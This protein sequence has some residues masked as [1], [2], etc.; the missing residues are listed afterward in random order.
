MSNQPL[1]QSS[2]AVPSDL[3]SLR[4]LDLKLFFAGMESANTV[5]P[6][7]R[8]VCKLCLYVQIS[9]SILLSYDNQREIWLGGFYTPCIQCF[10]IYRKFDSPKPSPW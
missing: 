9:S 4:L 2:V 10:T 1:E 7:P 5:E 8:K 6:R 3:S